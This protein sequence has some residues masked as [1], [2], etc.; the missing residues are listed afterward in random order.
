MG[1]DLGAAA[2][3]R[4][5]TTLLPAHDRV[6]LDQGA[7]FRSVGYRPHPGQAEIHSSDARFKVSVCG[8][9]FGKSEIGG[10]DLLTEAFY[11][12]PLAKT[13][14][15]DRKRRE[16]W[17]V[18]PEY[19]DAEKEFRVLW[20]EL[21]RLEVP[22]DQP[23]TYN[24]P[25][26]GNM[27]IS[28]WE[29]TYVVEAKS[30]KHPETLVGEGLSGLIVAE[31]AKVK[32]RVWLRYLR[33]TLN[34]FRGW[35][36]FTT[37]PEGKNWIYDLW[38]RGQNPADPAW[39]SFRKPS[40]TNPYVY[41]L[42]ATDAGIAEILRRRSENLL[43]TDADAIALGV[44]PEIAQLASDL[45]EE[46]FN[47]EIGADFTEFVGRVFKGFDEEVHVGDLK[48]NPEWQTFGAVDYGFRNP[49]VWLLVQVD[50]HGELV[51]VL[52][53]VYEKGLGPDQ[54]V[55]R[56]QEKHL[57]PSGLLAFYPDPASPGDTDVLERSLK[58]RGRPH[59][60]G[61]LKDRLDLIR[62]W[63]KPNLP[64]G[65]LGARPRL[66]FDR[67]CKESIRDFNDYRYPDV[68]TESDRNAPENPMKVNDHAPEALGRFM[69]GHFGT[70]VAQ[71]RTTRVRSANVR[72]R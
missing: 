46:A 9:R 22:F 40:W 8:R 45:T 27:R 61:P 21:K 52:G 72:R 44:D 31:A 17:I 33:S 42:G 65:T 1:G 25:V 29:G 62:T 19:S 15:A 39:A 32:E 53:E 28:L 37:T 68:R 58:V 24:N 14:L 67:S 2:Y 71:A 51:N 69:V 10:H 63:L 26:T 30:A 23:G 66:M 49:N 55:A 7:L 50:P 70:P 3:R 57:D 48:F 47:Q 64:E 20:N 41:P 36:E 59:T 60:G 56:I 12:A 5:V 11:T 35:A 38:Q 18:G 13:L 16:F 54:F 43:V 6:M 4:R 34:D